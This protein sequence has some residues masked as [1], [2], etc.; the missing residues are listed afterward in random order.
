[1]NNY[2]EDL[3]LV[4]MEEFHRKDLVEELNKELIE[5]SQNQKDDEK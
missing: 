1:M 4:E 2:H 3:S 5:C